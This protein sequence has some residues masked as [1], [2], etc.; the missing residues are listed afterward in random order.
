MEPLNHCEKDRYYYMAVDF[1]KRRDETVVTLL[2]KKPQ[3]F[4]IIRHISAWNQIDYSGQIG[5]I[6]H[7]SSMSTLSS[8][9]STRLQTYLS[10]TDQDG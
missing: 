10:L 5:R 4:L 9:P 7:R 8:P 6:L 2:E 3:G 1:A